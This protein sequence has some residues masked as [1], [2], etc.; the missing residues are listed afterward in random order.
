VGSQIRL[1]ALLAASVACGGVALALFGV[2][3]VVGAALACMLGLGVA[4]TVEYAA[5]QTLLQQAVP[6]TMIGRAAGTMGSFFLALM[7][8]GNVA[9]GLLAAWLGLTAAIAGLGALTVIAAGLAWWNL[10]RQTARQPD[11]AV[12]ARIPAFAPVPV[13][14]REW[15]VRRM[16]REQFPTGAVIVRQG[17]VGD[18]FYTI[19]SGKAQVEVMANGHRRT[20]ELGP[21]DFFGEIALLQNVP[22]TATVRA[23][24]PLTTYVLSR[25]DF[26]ELQNRAAEFRE[27]ML[28]A[29]AARLQQDT[30]IKLALAARS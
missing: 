2:W 30:N 21:G 7:L 9:S 14:V 3:P 28:A 27:S 17:D 18:T 15:A 6:Q 24:E 11:A 8:V 12:L 19:A 26:Q 23:L 1:D 13:A 10:R 29:A 20:G 4:E 22:R 16:R 25:D 5:Y